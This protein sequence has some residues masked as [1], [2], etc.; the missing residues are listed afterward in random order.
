MTK[1]FRANLSA[2]VANARA[3]V[4]DVPEVTETDEEIAIKL[5]DRFAAMATM[6]EATATGKNR[7]LIISGPAGLGKSYG[8]MTRLERLEAEGF[9]PVVIR[10]F[11]RP[12]GLY[13][14]LY[15]HRFENCVVVFD[16][17]DAV[18]S[19]ETSLNLLKTACDMTK[20][21]T[22]SWLTETRME[23]GEGEKLPRKFDFEGSII[24]ITNYDFDAMIASGNKMAPHFEAM[25]SR[26]HYLDLAMKTKRDYLVRIR[27][28]VKDHGMLRTQGFSLIQET[29]LLGF[30]ET[31]HERLREL[32]L[33][34]VLKLAGLM[35]MNPTGWEKLAKVTCMR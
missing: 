29:T 33:R 10:G 24:F 5:H 31:N 22:L 14:T 23:D 8:V 27:Q 11:V 6:T 2:R 20:K 26:S 32:S 21:R 16:D 1:N 30:I 13:K 7:S 25:I 4:F 15:E 12:T 18:F 3:G 19:D 17:A 9:T 34:M 28:V 35:K